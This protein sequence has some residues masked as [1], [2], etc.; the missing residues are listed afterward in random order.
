MNN[1]HVSDLFKTKYVTSVVGM[2]GLDRSSGDN[3]AKNDSVL[4]FALMTREF[5]IEFFE[6]IF[7]L[8]MIFPLLAKSMC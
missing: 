4:S 8:A 1:V 3:S 6:F 2:C 7:P 5:H